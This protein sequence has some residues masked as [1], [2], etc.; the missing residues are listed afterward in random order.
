MIGGRVD[1]IFGVVVMLAGVGGQGIQ[2]V[3]ASL[4]AGRRSIH[5][6]RVRSHVSPQTVLTRSTT[7][8]ELRQK[9]RLNARRR[10]SQKDDVGRRSAAGCHDP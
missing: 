8:E 4:K 10:A 1:V 2:R 9:L 3:C 5:S 6:G 7:L